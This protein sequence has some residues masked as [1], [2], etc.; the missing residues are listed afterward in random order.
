V[1]HFHHHAHQFLFVLS[2]RA[3]LEV[4]RRTVALARHHGLSVAAKVPHR[5]SNEE[6]EDVVFVPVSTPPSHGDRV[7]VEEAA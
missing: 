2:G 5:L 6:S 3:T 4:D 7:V 1:R